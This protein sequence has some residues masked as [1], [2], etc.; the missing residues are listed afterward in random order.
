MSKKL[1]GSFNNRV[2]ENSM[3]CDNVEVGTKV[4]SYSY[5]DRDIYEVVEVIS[6]KELII[7]DME[8]GGYNANGY[9]IAPASNPN[10]HMTRIVNRGGYWY[11]VS[12][13]NIADEQGKE[14]IGLGSCVIIDWLT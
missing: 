2:M 7:R 1:Y 11:T 9:A 12:S 6:D 5:T 3:F 10:G 4:T 13:Y 14:K 8:T